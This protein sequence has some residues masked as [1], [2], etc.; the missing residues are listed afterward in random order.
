MHS[1]MVLLEDYSKKNNLF[2]LEIKI[3]FSEANWIF[4]EM[5]IFLVK[6][7]YYAKHP[8]QFSLE[9]DIILLSN[10]LLKVDILK[11]IKFDCF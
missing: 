9:L 2:M 6:L 5:M 8:Y 11:M 4:Y 1:L 10:H 3:L 7:K